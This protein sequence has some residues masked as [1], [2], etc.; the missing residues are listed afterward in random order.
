MLFRSIRAETLTPLLAGRFSDLEIAYR[1]ALPNLADE[2]ALR[3]GP[4]RSHW[5]ARGPGL[6]A[7]I[8]RMTDDRLV[9]ERADVNLVQPAVG[10]GGVTHLPYNSVTIEAVAANPNEQLPEPVRLGWLLSQL[11]LDLP[12]F[13]ETIPRDR[14]PLVAGLAMVPLVLT[15]AE[16]VGWVGAVDAALIAT[17]I[18]WWR[19]PVTP[20]AETAEVIERWF[21]GYGAS[22]PDFG[23]ALTALDRLV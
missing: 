7:A 19:L 9:V 21:N 12:V 2:L 23:V 13:S 14:L 1:R 18:D 4:L 15:A 16:Q 3:A 5:E 22:K 10:G 6:L 11:N 8:A 17:A 20:A